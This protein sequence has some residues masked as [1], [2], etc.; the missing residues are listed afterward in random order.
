MASPPPQ[1]PKAIPVIRITLSKESGAALAE[2]IYVGHTDLSTWTDRTKSVVELYCAGPEELQEKTSWIDQQKG[3]W[4]DVLGETIDY[5]ASVIEREDWAET[6]KKYFHPKM[7]TERICIKPSW[8]ALS[9]PAPEC[10]IEID[11]GMSFGT[12]QHGTT[13]VCLE[14]LD[15]L[16]KEERESDFLDIGCGSGILSIAAA[17]LGMRSITAYDF[18]PIAV[19][20]TRENFQLNGVEDSMVFVGDVTSYVPTRQYAV[21][22]ANLESRI[23]LPNI[24]AIVSCVDDTAGS[25]LIISGILEDEYADVSS[26]FLE[27]GFEEI[28][29]VT[30]AE[31]RSGLLRRY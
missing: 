15:R 14:F 10:V 2:F 25:H 29:A 23:L 1:P 16:L 26:R 22:A 3:W 13:A 30:M 27:C 7:I 9:F 4:G 20:C 11:P 28:D 18:D 21:V 6:W 17:K 19:E 8:E 24:Q 31:W 5:E 12:G